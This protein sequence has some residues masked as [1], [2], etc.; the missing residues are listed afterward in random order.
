MK[1]I[2]LT[3]TSVLLLREDLTFHTFSTENLESMQLTRHWG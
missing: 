2:K 3:Y 1:Y